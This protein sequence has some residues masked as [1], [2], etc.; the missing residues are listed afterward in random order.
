MDSVVVIA[1]SNNALRSIRKHTCEQE[2]YEYQR[3]LGQYPK[4]ELTVLQSLP[5]RSPPPLLL[6]AV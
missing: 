2:G 3:V 5:T 1:R 6:P 4:V